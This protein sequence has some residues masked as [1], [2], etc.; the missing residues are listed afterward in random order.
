M[1]SLILTQSKLTTVGRL[2]LGA[3]SS[4]IILALIYMM[5][6]IDRADAIVH[7]WFI[8]ILTGV[9]LTFSCLLFLNR[10]TQKEARPDNKRFITLSS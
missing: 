5:A 9:C 1:K 8:A 7:L 3:G 10:N 4:I 2:L 6:N